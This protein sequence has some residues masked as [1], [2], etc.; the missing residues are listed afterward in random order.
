[1]DFLDNL[2]LQKFSKFH[3]AVAWQPHTLNPPLHILLHLINPYKYSTSRHIQKPTERL[4]QDKNSFRLDNRIPIVF[5]LELPIL[6]LE[7]LLTKLKVL[8]LTDV[9]VSAW[10]IRQLQTVLNSKSLKL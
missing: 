10:L 2:V 7:Y 6:S 1:M 4:P 9:I 5:V 3:L 8:G